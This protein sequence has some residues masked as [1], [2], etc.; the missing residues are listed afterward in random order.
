MYHPRSMAGTAR[1]MARLSFT[2]VMCG[3]YSSRPSAIGM[4]AAS[5]P[6]RNVRTKAASEPSSS[7]APKR[8]R[9]R[10]WP[11][12]RRW[13]S[14]SPRAAANAGCN[15]GGDTGVTVRQRAERRGEETWERTS[16]GVHCPLQGRL[17]PDLQH[18]QRDVQRR[19]RDARE[20]WAW[21]CA[22][23]DASAEALMHGQPDPPRTCRRGSIAVTVACTSC[24]TPR[25]VGSVTR[26]HTK[27]LARGWTRRPLPCSTGPRT[28]RG[29]R[30]RASSSG[31]GAAVAG[32]LA[33]ACSARH[34]STTSYSVTSELEEPNT[35]SCGRRAQRVG[36]WRREKG[37][38][39]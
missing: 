31:A 17:V 32:P 26:M 34:A 7:G 15:A 29:A 38:Q 14:C 33:A 19:R 21:A 12:P 35:L 1:A 5:M 37:A 24:A 11:R 9:S 8:T 39:R 10:K 22:I 2:S 4:L 6:A 30:A 23:Q 16:Q 36:G 20:L 18:A 25:M 3:V 27:K 28:P 13:S